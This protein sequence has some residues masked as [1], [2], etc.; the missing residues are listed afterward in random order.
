MIDLLENKWPSSLYLAQLLGLLLVQAYFQVFVSSFIQVDPI[1]A[2]VV[3]SIGYRWKSPPLWP[4]SLTAIIDCH[5]TLAT[6]TF[7]SSLMVE[8]IR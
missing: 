2:Q 6:T 5:Q 7:T 8:V 3:Q 1:L 4:P